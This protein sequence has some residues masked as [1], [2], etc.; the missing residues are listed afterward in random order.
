MRR[1]SKIPVIIILTLLVLTASMV[2]VACRRRGPSIQQVSYRNTWQGEHGG[3]IKS[4][5]PAGI[6]YHAPSGHL[7]LADSEINEISQW[8]GVNIFEV[9][10]DLAEIFS[11]HDA[12][13]EPR[14]PTGV[15]YNAFDGY[16]YI[17]D[18]DAHM[19]RRY[20]KEFGEP[21]HSVTT[22]DCRR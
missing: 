14:E 11:S 22:S 8:R 3:L 20:G 10:L 15:T 18:D 6:T 9:S 1:N 21:L 2:T 17:T 16:F 4:T 7:F 12:A 5:D 19:I 13:A